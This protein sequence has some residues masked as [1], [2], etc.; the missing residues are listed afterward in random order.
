MTC[1]LLKT[2]LEVM[3]LSK[4]IVFLTNITNLKTFFPSSL[5]PGIYIRGNYTRFA[6]FAIST[7]VINANIKNTNTEDTYARIAYFKKAYTRTVN[8]GAIYIRVIFDRSVF[9]RV[10]CC[11]CFSAV[12]SSRLLAKFKFWMP[13]NSC[14][15]LWVVFNKVL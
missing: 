8:I 4:M 3:F 15:C 14:L 6:F 12:L 13:V 7:Y 2:S 1:V 5:S 10:A 9:I 11:I